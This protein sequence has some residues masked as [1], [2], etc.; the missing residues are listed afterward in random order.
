M[1][2]H[3]ALHASKISDDEDLD[4]YI[5]TF[6]QPLP[7][8]GIKQ[9]GEDWRSVAGSISTDLATAHLAGRLC[10]ATL[11]RWYPEFGIFD[12]DERSIE[13][14]ESTRQALGLDVTNSMLCRS[15]RKG[16]YHLLFKPRFRDRPPTLKLF[17]DI[18]GGH[19]TKLGFELYPS[20]NHCI[21]L[22]FGPKQRCIDG[23]RQRLRWRELLE[24]FRQLVPFNLDFVEKIPGASAPRKGRITRTA[25][26]GHDLS[27]YKAGAELLDTGLVMR[28]SRN[29]SQFLVL[30]YLWRRGIDRNT[31]VG[32]TKAWIRDK[33]NGLSS[34]AS[35]QGWREIDREIDRQAAT[36]WNYKRPT[37]DGPRRFGSRKAGWICRDDLVPILLACDGDLRLSRFFFDLLNYLYPRVGAGYYVAVHT[38][39]LS[40]F[41]GGS[42]YL[43]NLER[44]EELGHVTRR[45]GYR[46]GI[47]SKKIHVNWN[48]LLDGEAFVV[49]GR[50]PEN[51]DKALAAAFERDELVELLKKAG[52]D[53]RA[54]AS[55]VRSLA[56]RWQP[57][58]R[59]YD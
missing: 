44:L 21:R 34:T 10:I 53:A 3:D 28:A 56:K 43:E 33:H 57:K 30:Y 18:M 15:E 11:G 41:S 20:S 1:A 59:T 49:E 40:S 26:Q 6:V 4:E 38:R 12:L 48:F 58:P 14:V 22:P 42:A 19:A 7:R 50:S 36:I 32:Q 8:Y 16:H 23:S 54:I 52:L 17:H 2:K 24:C 39:V 5:R 35:A 25:D 46:S 37:A 55:I 13:E 51:L 29:R 47:E 45:G 9:P 31:A 27:D